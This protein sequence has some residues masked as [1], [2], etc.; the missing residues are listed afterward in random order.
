MHAADEARAL[1]LTAL[2]RAEEQPLGGDPSAAL[3]AWLTLNAGYFLGEWVTARTHLRL[4]RRLAGAVGG[5]AGLALPPDQIA[6]AQLAQHVRELIAAFGTTPWRAE[7]AN[8]TAPL[9]PAE[10]DDWEA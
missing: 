5:I 2:A 9:L 6:A 7:M 8:V 1:Y 4:V 10:A 3:A